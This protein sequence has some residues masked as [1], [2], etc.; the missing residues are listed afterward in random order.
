MNLLPARIGHEGNGV[1]ARHEPTGVTLDLSA[2]PFGRT[3]EDGAEVIVGLRPEHFSPGHVNGSKAGAEF[4]M[5]VRYIET[6]GSD[7]TMFLDGGRD[8]LISVRFDRNLHDVP[9]VGETA[10]I[11]FPKDRFDVFDPKT[12][13]RL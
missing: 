9:K 12:E 3:P 11:H 4:A 6:T 7:V 2:Y 13:K 10:P 8:G 5:P 1:V